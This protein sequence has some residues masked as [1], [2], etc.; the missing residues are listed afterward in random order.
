MAGLKTVDMDLD[1]TTGPLRFLN[2]KID[3]AKLGLV[4]N[5]GFLAA[6]LSDLRFYGGVG[7]GR[8]EIDARGPSV[9]VRN[10]LAAQN[11]NAMAFF[12]DAMNFKNLE[13][14]AKIDWDLRASGESQD[15]LMHSVVGDGKLALNN[16]A[17]RGVN[18]GGLSK[19]IKDAIMGGMIGPNARTPFTSFAGTFKAQKGVFATQDFLIQGADVTIKAAGVIDMGAQSMDMR[20]TPRSASVFSHLGFKGAGVSAP[21]LVR[22]PWSKLTYAPDLTGSARAEV[23]GRAKSVIG[24]ETK[25]GGVLGQILGGGR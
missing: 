7:T 11:V 13:G 17:L 5:D 24:G 9:N 12:T 20:I 15:A 23:E 3:G 18:L 22:G 8:V 1:L 25:A 14:A 6:T 10:V 4:L 16:G 19:T 2:Y 21:F